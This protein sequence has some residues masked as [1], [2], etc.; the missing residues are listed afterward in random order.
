[1]QTKWGEKKFD[2]NRT[3]MQ[4]AILNKS[5]KQNSS[6]TPTYFPSQKPFKSD[7]Q[8]MQDT[9]GKVKASSYVTFFH[10]PLHADEQVLDVRL[11][12]VSNSSVHIHDVVSMTCRKQ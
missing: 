10:E 5:L 1:M 9:A 3:R 12:P 4:T 8:D 7:E 11:N 6:C 2:G